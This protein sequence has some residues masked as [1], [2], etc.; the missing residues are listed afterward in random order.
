[1][2]TLNLKNLDQA[3]ISILDNINHLIIIQDLD[4]NFVYVNKVITE[5]LGYKQEELIGLPYKNALKLLLGEKHLQEI[6]QA[7]DQVKQGNEVL[8]IRKFSHKMGS[9]VP[10]EEQAMPIYDI[11]KQFCGNMLVLKNLHE[12]LIVKVTNLVNSTL[13]LKEVLQNTTTAVVEYL[14]L[15]SNAVFLLDKETEILQLVSCNAFECE[16]DYE[17]I[18]MKIG[19]GAPGKI[20]A[21]RKPIY[22]RNLQTDPLIHEDARKLHRAKSTIGYPLICKEELLGVIA[23]D[24]DI[25]RE[26]TD[27]EKAIFQNIASQ[28]ALAIYNAQLFSSL[29]HLAITDGL[30]GLYNHR[31]FHDRLEEE[32]ERTLRGGKAF[33]LLICDVDYFKKYNDT[34]GHLSGDTFLKRIAKIIEQSAR[35]PDV[36]ARYGGEEFAVILVDCE[37]R[38]AEVIAQRIRQAVEKIGVDA[39]A[40]P[41]VTISIGVSS[42][43]GKEIKEQIIESADKALYKA[44]KYGRNRV[45]IAE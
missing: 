3:V 40:N 24:A 6:N 16:E 45:E 5:I 2:L 17:K 9:T 36:V 4:G 44:K 14:G 37:I 35:R 42:F 19:E 34:F 1:M 38:E 20:A 26:F 41:I 8:K 21:E 31:Y 12:E 7:K 27:K 10:L 29:E 11:N 33:S 18:F 30:T 22:V 28:V 43:T 15:D 23:F 13:S 39:N 32:I 25:I